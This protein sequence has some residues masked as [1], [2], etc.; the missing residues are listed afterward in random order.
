VDTAVRLGA[1]VV[2]NSYGIQESGF[3]A[4]FAH[5]YRH[6]GHVIVASSGDSGFTAAE[7]PANQA[8]VTAVGGTILA[9]AQG[10]ARGYRERAWNI[11]FAGATGSGCSAYVAKP[12]W[13]HD[14]HCP[15]GRMTAD[16]AAV[17]WNLAI[18]DSSFL[19]ND[20]G[21]WLEA[22][23]T[24]ASAPLVAG[25]YGLAGNAATVRSGGEY[26]HPGALF[27]VTKGTNVPSG[28][29]GCGGDYLCNAKPGYDGPTGLGTPN[30]TGAF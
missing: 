1:A 4:P 7:F 12:A 14:T 9:H 3:D 6:P 19:P 24:S 8:S 16:V 5:S 21:P 27:D 25:V 2:S 11:T 17:A 18:Y 29:Q 15:Q 26:A 20:G 28:G 23:G 30:G 22:A 10:T 13:Q